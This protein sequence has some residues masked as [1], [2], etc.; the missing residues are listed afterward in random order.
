[1]EKIYKIWRF[2]HTNRWSDSP[3]GCRDRTG[4]RGPVPSQRAGTAVA[5]FT[6]TDENSIQSTFYYIILKKFPDEVKRGRGLVP[7]LVFGSTNWFPISSCYQ[8]VIS[9]PCISHLI[10]PARNFIPMVTKALSCRGC[11]SKQQ[12]QGEIWGEREKLI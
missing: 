9:L 5:V 12:W 6:V 10:V 7:C 11:Q 2:H 1:V 3:R 4:C 8:A